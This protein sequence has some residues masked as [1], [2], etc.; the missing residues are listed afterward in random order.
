MRRRQMKP[1]RIPTSPCRFMFLTPSASTPRRFSG[2]P[3]SACARNAGKICCKLVKCVLQPA[4]LTIQKPFQQSIHGLPSGSVIWQLQ[5]SSMNRP[6]LHC[7]VLRDPWHLVCD[8]ILRLLLASCLFSSLGWEAHE[9]NCCT[10]LFDL[11]ERQA[12]LLSKAHPVTP[13]PLHPIFAVAQRP[14]APNTGSLEE[15]VEEESI[16][17]ESICL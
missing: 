3:G 11:K 6:E 10:R 13:G 1:D 12:G 4:I 14:N 7:E 9:L 15:N 5:R 17:A 8:H 2:S 16:A